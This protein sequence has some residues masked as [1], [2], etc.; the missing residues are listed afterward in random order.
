M[1][2]L[3]YAVRQLLKA[4]AFTTV[5]V[6]SLA[7]G[8]GASTMAFSW[9][10]RILVDSV[11]GAKD[12]GRLVVLASRHSSGRISDTLSLPDASDLAAETNVFQG[13]LASQI[14][15]VNVRIQRDPEWLWVQPTTA[16]FFDLL[17]VRPI[18][19]RGFHPEEDDAPGGNGVVVISHSLWQ[20]RFAGDP[21]VLGRTLEISRRVF[22][23]IGVAPP[24]F[25]G[26][27]GGLSF[28][29]WV[30]VTMS[31]EHTDIARALTS[32]GIRWLHTI[33]RLEEGVSLREAQAAVDIAMRRLESAH[34]NSNRNTGV[35]VLPVWKSPWG[36]Q[37]LLLPL[38]TA[39]AGMALLLLLLVIAN[40][41]NLLLAR[42]IT[43][44]SE[45]SV[46][47]ALG[48]NAG[49]LM[50]QVL[51]ESLVLAAAGGVAGCGMAMA[52]LKALLWSFPT[53]YLPIHLEFEID[54]RVLAFN[55]AITLI[56]GMLFGLAPAWRATR[57]NIADTLK[58]GGR[59]GS[60][61][62]HGHRLRQCLVIGEVAAAVILLVGMALCARS[63]D[64]AQ[65]MYVGFNPERVWV[66]GFRLPPG[67][68]SPEKAAAFY[69]RLR[70]ELEQIPS[71][72]S[73]ALADWL[74]LGF[75][76]GS[77][78]GF[79]VPGY[80]PSP[81]ENVEAGV[82]TVSSGY[83]K[84]LQAP[85][86]DGREF[87][88]RD[89]RDAPR[90]VIINQEIARR[91]FPGRNPLGLPLQIWGSERTIIGI[92]RTSP[93]RSL[94]EPPRPYLYLPLEQVG[95]HTLTAVIRT[96]GNPTAIAGE[97]ERTAAS[98]DPQARPM[99]ST[100]MTDF[101]AAAYLVPETAAMLLAVL[102]VAALL[103]S[104]LGIYGIIA[105]SVGRRTREVGIRMALGAERRSV[106]RMFLRQGLRLVA[107]GTA[108]GVLGSLLTGR[109]LGQ[110]LVD[111]SPFDP[112]S[113]GAVIPILAL[114]GLLACWLPA[115]RAAAIDLLKALREE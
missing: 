33:A 86:L 20:R 85:I 14:E 52:L 26:T 65:H 97:V 28:D 113:Y 53:T 59:S 55:A 31:N 12:P 94:N 16:N 107:L 99:A 2:D 82:S 27:M 106:M 36:A 114:I 110:L 23:I 64:R 74:P 38:L 46:R 43:R 37:G 98:I 45:M 32:R 93:Y 11:P 9:I 30:P 54:G 87:D 50:R 41:A 88:A 95:D 101:M 102:G 5:A 84:T 15:A 63:F 108:I 115:R 72:T 56:T 96:Q 44:E 4:P 29:L 70:T 103:L 24:E 51:I 10:Q 7:V 76:G 105:T 111:V 112:A 17:G 68:Y 61:S 40:I 109:L 80:Q 8:I 6:L 48:A 13:V 58:A 25:R 89:H 66:A 83:F 79:G 21:Q 104:A 77:S 42:A 49:R 78:T 91:Y 57:A 71:V 3:R 75:E 60:G 35:A 22:T 69:Q 39:L 73:V 81:G 18:L 34:P 47:L 92:A 1:N 90:V 19:G 67:S 100:A 62:R